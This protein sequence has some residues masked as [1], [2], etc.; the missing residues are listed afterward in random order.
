M[1]KPRES[2]TL[3]EK[4]VLRM[5]PNKSVII[6]YDSPVRGRS[7][8]AGERWTEIKAEEYY[9]AEKKGLEGRVINPI[10]DCSKV[11]KIQFRRSTY[12]HAWRSY[13]H[14]KE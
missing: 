12:G 13:I 1:V 4:A 6:A 10:A 9:N 14:L 3:R 7:R 2:Y 11:D 5:C 8:K